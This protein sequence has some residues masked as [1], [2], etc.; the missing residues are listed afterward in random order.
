MKIAI[1][2]HETTRCKRKRAPCS[3]V[4]KNKVFDDAQSP[5][6]KTLQSH[7]FEKELNK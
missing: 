2:Q 5:L 6:K 3:K 7:T 1:S 4:R